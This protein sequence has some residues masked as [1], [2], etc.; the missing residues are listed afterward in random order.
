M[1]LCKTRPFFVL[2]V[3]N[4]YSLVS[5]DGVNLGAS[6]SVDKLG[7]TPSLS[8]VVVNSPVFKPA[9]D[10]SFSISLLSSFPEDLEI[11][12]YCSELLH[13]FGQ[14]YVTY[15]NCLIP[16]ARPVHVCQNC[17]ASYRSLL[18]IYANISSEQMG[19]G[20]VSCKDSLLRS[21]RLMLVY[22]LY[23]NLEG[24]WTKS[25]CKYC[26]TE[27]LQS[28]TN[29]T[30]YFMMTLNQ[31]LTCFEKYQQ[32]NH[33]ELC[34]N[35][36]SSYKGLNELYSRMENN[37]TLCIDIED[38]MNMTRRLWSKNFNCSFPRE[39]TVPV[40]AVSSFMLFL[41]IIFYLSS[42]LHS[43]QKKRKLIHPKRAK[44]YTTLMNIQDK[45]T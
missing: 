28:L 23:S 10:S 2:L 3:I 19:P 8:H 24:L 29:D 14:R 27:G 42:F 35:C 21:D 26:I 7:Q 16:A 15:V 1:S 39:E 40:I 5:S 33:T 37:H 41:P 18:D 36:K 31:T 22:L 43:E 12:D 6:D 20:N 44:S 13:I 32:G 34:K 45:L 30:L 25:D 38:A 17:F 9:L 4:I 11:S